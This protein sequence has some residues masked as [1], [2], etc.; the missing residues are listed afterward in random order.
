MTAVPAVCLG[1]W[2][3]GLEMKCHVNSDGMYFPRRVVDCKAGEINVG[4]AKC[5]LPVQ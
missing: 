4:G 2:L 5:L 3:Q 1:L